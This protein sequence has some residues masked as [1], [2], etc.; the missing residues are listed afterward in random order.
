ML[1]FILL[2][3]P[4]DLNIIKEIETLRA[5]GNIYFWVIVTVIPALGTV[6]AYLFMRLQ[7][8]SDK[9]EETF[10]EITKDKFKEK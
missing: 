5:I 9:L 10:M 1:D 4:V 7:A 2:D 6:I 3:V 8:K